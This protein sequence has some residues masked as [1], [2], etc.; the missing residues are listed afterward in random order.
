M[1]EYLFEEVK[2]S[3]LTGKPKEDYEEIIDRYAANG[4]RY[5]GYI[6]TNISDYGKIKDMDLIFEKDEQ[7]IRIDKDE[8]SIINKLYNYDIF[9]AMVKN[10]IE[11]NDYNKILLIKSFIVFLKSSSFIKDPP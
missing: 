6:P 8:I 1:Y 2:L 11:E 3:G 10:D 7:V 5:V 4:Y 9:N